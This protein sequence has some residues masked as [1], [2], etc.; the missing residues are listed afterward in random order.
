M[1][2]VS[3]VMAHRACRAHRRAED[4]AREHDAAVAAHRRW[5]LQQKN[6]IARAR[7]EL[8]G[9][10]CGCWCV[11]QYNCHAFTLAEVA[12][13]SEAHLASL[14]RG[15]AAE[16]EATECDVACDELLSSD[17]ERCNKSEF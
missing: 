10:R 12:N 5:F 6:E 8:R 15:M 4:R 1:R 3:E 13:C 2:K 14:V 16:V 7:C 17:L 11:P 9:K